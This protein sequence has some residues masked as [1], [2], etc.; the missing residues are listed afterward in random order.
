MTEEGSMNLKAA[1]IP[2]DT[3]PGGKITEE[4]A[5]NLKAAQYPSDKNP[6]GI[7]KWNIEIIVGKSTTY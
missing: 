5:M 4:A 6:G 7:R 3:N 1:Q 2:S